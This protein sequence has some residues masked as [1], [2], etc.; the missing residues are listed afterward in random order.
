MTLQSPL[1]RLACVRPQ[2]RNAAMVPLLPASVSS[3]VLDL[4]AGGPNF[5][6]P[7][8]ARPELYARVLWLQSSFWCA[9]DVARLLQHPA[10]VACGLDLAVRGHA[11]PDTCTLQPAMRLP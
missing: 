5:P 9:N 10:D 3:T 4:S 8:L 11:T 1:Q 7:K 2:L 6:T